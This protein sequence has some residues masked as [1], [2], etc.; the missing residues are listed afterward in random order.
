[1]KKIIFKKIV[2]KKEII[3]KTVIT[4]FIKKLQSTLLSLLPAVSNSFFGG[5]VGFDIYIFIYTF[6]FLKYEI[7]S[8]G[9]LYLKFARLKQRKKRKPLVFLSRCFPFF[10]I[11][12]L[13]INFLSN[14]IFFFS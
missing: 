12:C 5:A 1:M 3:T 7:E 10:F 13:F 2:L 6:I 8:S 4:K 14:S 9:K 11:F